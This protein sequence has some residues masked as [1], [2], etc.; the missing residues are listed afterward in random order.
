[1]T[2]ELDY[3][4]E[5]QPLP[6]QTVLEAMLDSDT[7]IDPDHLRRLSDLENFE[8]EQFEA[9]WEEIPSDRRHLLLYQV[10]E[11]GRN[12]TVLSYE[13]LGRFTVSDPDPKVRLFA[14]QIL[15]EYERVDISEVYLD[16]LIN[17]PDPRVRAAA[18]TGLGKFIL[19]G[20]LDKVP[21]LLQ[22]RIEGQLIQLVDSGRTENERQQ[23]LE[24][25]GF[26]SNPQV[27]AMIE[28]EYYSDQS[29]WVVCS[30]RAMGNSANNRW[31]QM[32]I[33]NLDS[34]SPRI[35][36]AAA[37]AAGQLEIHECVPK[38]LEMLDDPD[39]SVRRNCITA[40]S[41]T[42]GEG[43]RER[44]EMLYEETFWSEDGKHLEDA[45]ENLEFVERN[46]LMPF[47]DL[48]DDDPEA[49]FDDDLEWD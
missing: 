35:R 25:L 2:D 17:D 4:E 27:I 5:D 16:L 8:L 19:A 1:M 20:E 32:V 26:S 44:L 36:S 39:E 18:A 15:W 12:D 6:F 49:P 42:G 45:L 29:G 46:S 7:P 28:R 13:A 11:L 22:Q 3:L 9:A 24:S 38:L 43:V 37:R 21:K 23:A 41:Q 40:L 34:L 31:N 33:T 48:P 14:A 10:E 30:L 47:F